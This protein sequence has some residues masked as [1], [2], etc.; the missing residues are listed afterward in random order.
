MVRL[1]PLWVTAPDFALP[2][3]QGGDWGSLVS[4]VPSLAEASPFMSALVQ[5]TRK[6]AL[7]YGGKYSKAWHTNM[8]M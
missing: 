5:I 1:P 4:R 2:V 7:V 8:P 3:T 6:I